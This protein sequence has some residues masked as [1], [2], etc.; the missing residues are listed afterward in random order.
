MTTRSNGVLFAEERRQNIL[1]MLELRDN[2]TVMEL[3]E[4]FGLS[5]A[6]IRN[7]LRELHHS[8]LLI[9]THGGAVRRPKA[10]FEL[11]AGQRKVQHVATKRAIAARAVE[12]I[13]NGDRICL[14]T[15]TTTLELAKC[16]RQARDLTILTN[17]LEIARSTEEFEGVDTILLGGYLRK[18]F[19]CTVGA[20]T[21]T[22]LGEFV[23]DKAFLGINGLSLQCGATTPDLQQARTKQ[24]M[25]A[26]A[27]E[28]ILLCDHS[29]FDTDCFARFAT[30]EDIDILITDAINDTFRHALEQRGVKVMVAD[31]S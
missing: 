10:G 20:S 22:A 6:T 24:A 13:T 1:E 15:G 30:I 19:H 9:R 23:V 21:A 7:D 3:C 8:G 18:G 29:K 25:I 27:K 11:N 2:L 17:D 14:D 26:A 5:G 4:L 31:E 28:T 16:L 12:L